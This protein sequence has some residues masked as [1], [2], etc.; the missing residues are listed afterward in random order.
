[1]ISC[2]SRDI[3]LFRL[4]IRLGWFGRGNGIYFDILSSG[5]IWEAGWA[6]ALLFLLSIVGR[7]LASF[8]TYK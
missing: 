4:T 1:M 6:F 5:V 8:G 3:K 7:V 2:D